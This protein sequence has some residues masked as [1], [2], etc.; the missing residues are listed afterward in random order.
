M[1]EISIPGV[2]DKYKTNDYIDALMK[3]ERIPLTREQESLDRYKEQHG[4]WRGVNQKMSALRDSTKTLY[5]FENPFNNKIANSS[6]ERAITAEA[7]RDATVESIKVDV[8]KEAT[9]DKF[10]SQGLDKSSKVPKGVYTFEIGEKKITFNW[11]GGKVTDFVNSLNKRGVNTLKA[12]LVGISDGKSALAIESLKTGDENRLVLK[13]DALTFALE[14]KIVEKS[15]KDVT[16]FGTSLS[17]FESPIDESTLVNSKISETEQEGMPPLTKTF[18]DF[19]ES[20]GKIIVPPRSGFTLSIPEEYRSITSEVFEFSYST[21]QVE[22]L[23]EELNIKR[24]TRPELPNV[25]IA[26]FESITV[27]NEQIETNL[28]PV[29]TEPLLP[30]TGHEDFYI[31]NSDGSEVKL[32]SAGLS[33]DSE[34]GEKTISFSLKDYPDAESIVVRN[35]NTGTQLAISEFS[36][37]DEKKNLGYAPVNPVSEAGDAVI[38]Y[39]G[40]TITRP[41]NKIDDVV[42]HVTLNVKAP[43]K[44]TATIDITSDKEAAKNALIE[45]VGRYNQVLAEMT[46]LSENKPEIITE[47]DYLSDAEKEE[48]EAKLGMFQNDFSLTNGKSSLRAI[49]TAN[50]RWSDEATLTMLNQIGISSRASGSTGGYVASQMRGYLEIDEK[51]LDSA[52]DEHMDEIKNLFGYDSDGD[53]VVDSG[54]GYA[55]DRQLTSW[56]QSGGIIAS[57]NNGI[58]SKIKASESKIRRLETQL[59]SKESQ[60]RNKYGQM[61]GTLNNLNAQSATVSNF[62]NNGKQ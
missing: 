52:L 13:D 34:T 21:E 11:K 4:A 55:I 7:G 16:S 27:E 60:L 20:S 1:A 26:T 6:D 41:T 23:T 46:I 9:A 56:T 31:H 3:K 62:A 53:L 54:I 59:S 5:S 36:T 44:E 51:K 15:K 8:I 35:R 39:E 25:G 18:V 42:P 57:K 45:F 19:D 38:K 22:D 10:L 2:S 32:E 30:I 47:L 40:I 17:E 58:D 43:T 33:I 12:S 49:V 14:N 37:Y 48:A 29:S 24:T 50:Y 61:E 28:P